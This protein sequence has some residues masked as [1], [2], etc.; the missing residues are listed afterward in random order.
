MPYRLLTA[1]AAVLV[2]ATAS[3]GVEPADLK[4]GLV[5]AYLPPHKGP[6][7]PPL[8]R[9][10]P[11]VALALAKGETPHPKLPAFGGATWSGYV[12]VT[13]PGKYTFSANVSNGTLRVTVGGKPVLTASADA[14]GEAVQLDGGVH[15]FEAT[16][17]S[18][19]APCRVELF[20]QGP[21][22]V[23]EPLP[24]QF[25]GHLAADR[26]ATFLKD[27]EEDRGRFL[28]EELAC[29]R[30]HSHARDPMAKALA[31]RPGPNLGEIGKRAYP[32]WIDAWLADP[33]KHRPNTTMP[34]LFADDDRGKAE[35][36]AVTRYLV[37]LTG[38]PLDAPK[39][40]AIVPPDVKQS[41]DRGR[42]LY[43]VTGCAACHEQAKPK[44]KNEEDDREPRKPEDLVFGVPAKYALGAVGSKTRPEP[45][46]AYLQNPLK[47]APAG[48]MPHMQLNAQ[49]ATDLARHLC[50]ATDPVVKPGM[51]AAPATRPADLLAEP[52]AA[53]ARLP[54][55][56]QWAAV[57]AKLFFSKGCVN[58]H[59]VD[60]AGKAAEPHPFATLADVRKAGAKGCV[61][62]K[63]DPAK[64]PVYTL[65]A[66]DRD[67]VVAFLKTGLD[68]AGS[69]APAFAARVALKRFN[70]LNCHS[71]D[72]EGGIPTDLADQM[73]LLEK[74]ENAD[75][76]R[77]PL[78][79]GVG[80]KAR[81]S[82]LKSVL[83]GGGRARPWMQLRMPQY[84]E[85]NVGH[86]PESLAALEGT[87]PD[88]AVHAVSVGAAGVG[89]GQQIVGK[90]GLGCIS[91]HDIGG[92]AN[93][94]T[95]GPDLSTINQRVRY[96]WYERWL[97]QPLRM[98]PG[99]RMPQAFVEGKSTLS[100]VLGGDPKGQAEAMWGYLAL[101]P[102]LPLPDGLEPPKGLTVVV[103][104]RPE[105]LRT[106]LP[107]AGTRAVAVGYP[108][109]VNVA[110]SADQ[111]RTAFAWSGNF[112]DA[113]PVW[114]NRGGAP[115]K[116]LGPKVWSAPPGHPWG[117]TANPHVPP[118][119]ARR[120]THPAFGTPAPL[121]ARIV[122]GPPAVRF[123]GYSLGADG[124]PM[125]R[126][127]L[128]ENDRDAVLKVAETPAPVRAAVA[129]GFVRTFTLEAPAGYT[130]WLLAGQS[131]K[132]P[133][134]VGAA[135]DLK[136][137]APAVPAAG[138]R[139]VLPQDGDRVAVLE[140]TGAPA[141][142][143]WRF[144][145]RAGG[146][147]SAVLRL[148]AAKDPWAGAFDLVTWVLKDDPALVK[149]LAAAK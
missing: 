94:G 68:G 88:D 139:V 63:P 65:A 42:V 1:A 149:D 147:W 76:I 122:D 90:G 141:G 24:H 138:V 137:D 134:V 8:T 11:T 54:A 140:A 103:R 18:A 2:A 121:E 106:F 128:V 31:D 120:A 118:D 119:F 79:T 100:T 77:P 4:P 12:N 144:V 59:S 43:T 34:K 116:L 113:T 14:T 91:C 114:N 50:Q 30:C 80:H 52:D 115:A 127:R 123:D 112:L 57:G 28:F 3:R 33:A 27:A 70:C 98:A 105:V 32:G 23:R 126:Y 37:S 143:A 108:G 9:L 7:P 83:V 39:P 62:P 107:D 101:G 5:A 95:R 35:R 41:L 81:T 38:A 102:T 129:T 132:D 25:L 136:A 82:W 130:G 97:H 75:D 78:L 142:A 66:K 86:L 16:F 74:A 56:G 19:G 53:V 96:D 15:R 20:W 93:T 51:P 117:L 148:P 131:A 99:T 84:G 46:A 110:F 64:V 40:P 133:R 29:A 36:Y 72:G 69:P 26:P 111:C 10:E 109:G 67:A 104:N 135:L 13:R 17:A 6:P 55:D 92:V 61:G 21:G 124:R 58:C 71:R 60:P 47:T 73:R 146:G 49:E 85:P 44:P 125:F 48:R 87:V 89:V 22:F 145:P 45:L